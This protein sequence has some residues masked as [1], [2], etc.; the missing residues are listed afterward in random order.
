MDKNVVHELHKFS[1][2]VFVLIREISG[3]TNK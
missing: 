2:I 1:R 3:Q